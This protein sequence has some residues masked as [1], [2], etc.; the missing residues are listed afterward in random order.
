MT[1]TPCACA[2]TVLD[3]TDS[4]Q[5]LPDYSFDLIIDKGDPRGSATTLLPA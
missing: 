2:V 5:V 3:A 4:E 1:L